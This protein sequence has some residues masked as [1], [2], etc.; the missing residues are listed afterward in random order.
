M[1]QPLAAFVQGPDP[2]PG[3]RR[4][5]CI[6]RAAEILATYRVSN[7]GYGGHVALEA[8]RKRFRITDAVWARQAA[9]LLEK[10]LNVQAAHPHH[11]A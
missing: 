4:Y 3:Y 6:D 10:R 9:K 11:P 1:P 7:C 8:A 2:N 5:Y